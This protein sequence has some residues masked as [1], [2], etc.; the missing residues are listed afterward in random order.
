MSSPADA[1]EPAP[2]D[3]QVVRREPPVEPRPPRPE[4]YPRGPES[5]LEPRGFGK[6]NSDPAPAAAARPRTQVK[7]F[8]KESLERLERKTV[9]LVR[10]YGFQPRRKLSVED[11]SRLPAKFEPFPA[12]LYGRPLEEIDNFIY[13]ERASNYRKN[14]DH[15]RDPKCTPIF[16]RHFHTTLATFHGPLPTQNNRNIT[17]IRAPPRN[18]NNKNKLRPLTPDTG[19]SFP[20]IGAPENWR[21]PLFVVPQSAEIYQFTTCKS[22]TFDPIPGPANAPIH[23]RGPVSKRGALTHHPFFAG[24]AFNAKIRTNSAKQ[25]DTEATLIDG[26]VVVSQSVAIKAPFFQIIGHSVEENNAHERRSPECALENR[27]APRRMLLIT[28]DRC[29]CESRKKIGDNH[30]PNWFAAGSIFSGN[31]DAPAPQLECKSS[32]GPV[33][34]RSC[35]SNLSGMGYGRL[36]ARK[37]TARSGHFSLQ[38]VREIFALRTV[39]Y[40]SGLKFDRLIM[41]ESGEFFTET[42]VI[43]NE[44]FRWRRRARFQDEAIWRRKEK[45]KERCWCLCGAR[46]QRHSPSS[47]IQTAEP[48]KFQFFPDYTEWPN[49]IGGF[50]VPAFTSRVTGVRTQGL[51]NSAT[52]RQQPTGILDWHSSPFSSG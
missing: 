48:D 14:I 46:P 33:R 19:T 8:T 35:A 37:S 9:Q 25:S 51:H 15:G 45:K 49:S 27:V 13:D 52:L 3:P 47:N 28:I 5:R 2:P 38:F 39:S 16:G 29:M 42:C 20:L 44:A 10:E 22:I 18:A 50:D 24:V 43:S 26:V 11:G 17:V 41:E 7:P 32:T 1:P 40:I 12:K 21:L 30:R 4:S 34:I 31:C 36:R 23:F 6:R